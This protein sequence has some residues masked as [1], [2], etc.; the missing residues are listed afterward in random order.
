MRD[1]ALD[2][3]GVQV[4]WH[5]F[6]GSKGGP[7][8]G[9]DDDLDLG[10]MPEQTRE[11]VPR[12]T[13]NARDCGRPI[14]ELGAGKRRNGALGLNQPGTNAMSTQP[15]YPNVARPAGR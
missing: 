3:C 11:V 1:F 12:R 8:F 15:A 5:T 6:V 7:R 13:G 14:F 10:P 4:G 2:V 9:Q